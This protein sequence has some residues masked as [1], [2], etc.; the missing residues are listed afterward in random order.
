MGPFFQQHLLIFVFLLSQFGNFQNI[1]N[2]C[3]I[4]IW[5]HL[6]WWTRI[7][8]LWCY[9][10]KWSWHCKLR[11]WFEFFSNKVFFNWGRYFFL[12]IMFCTLKGRHYSLNI[13]FIYPGKPIHLW[14]ELLQFLLYCSGLE[15]TCSIAKVCLYLDLRVQETSWPLPQRENISIFV[16][17]EYKQGVENKSTSQNILHS[18][19]HENNPYHINNDYVRI[20]TIFGSTFILIAA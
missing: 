5:W 20:K 9:Y 1:L 15:Q 3:T 17:Q 12:H 11:G 6:L 14:L 19:R 13:T 18:R 10:C 16:C 7:R 2:F 8:D 4:A